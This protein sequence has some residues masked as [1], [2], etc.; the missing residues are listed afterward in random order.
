MAVRRVFILGAGFSKQGG[1]PLAA[2][3][4]PLLLQKFKDID[5]QE[6]L[7]WFDWLKE[8]ILWLEKKSSSGETKINIEEVFD[9]AKFD[10][11]AWRLEHHRCLV[12]RTAGQTPWQTAKHIDTWLGYME[13]DLVDIIH[14]HQKKADITSIIKF[15]KCLG[16]NDVVLT[17][18][19]DTLLETALTQAGI[20]WCHGFK[21]EQNTG[22]T[23][24]KM[25][26]SIDWLI[27]GRNVSSH[28]N[29]VDLL[30]R[31]D[32]Q[33][34]NNTVSDKPASELEFDYELVRV[35]NDKF[36]EA[37]VSSR[38]LQHQKSQYFFA[39]AGLGSYKPLHHVP[40]LGEVW[41][42]GM[43]ALGQAEQIHIIGFS[44]SPFDNMARLSFGGVMCQRHNKNNLPQKIT[45][46]DPNINTLL[47]NFQ[48]VFGQN[49]PILPCQKRAEEI[50]W[51]QFLS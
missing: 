32:D 43:N 22:V 17:F 45:L 26:G 33:N 51:S 41:W 29:S 49:T 40:G 11:E 16:S 47:P 14:E 1:M 38:H 23:I 31:K 3:L 7:Q 39:L 36:L 24:C 35:K 5:D 34:R 48:A 30:F 2:E 44:L 4:T 8:R 9:L 18:N 10:V 42:K 21:N 15:A 50:D 37:F 46:I 6:V 25:H 27:M 12:G 20:S 13:E 19:Y 28:F